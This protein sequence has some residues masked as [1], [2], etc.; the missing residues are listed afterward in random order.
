M[1]I[2]YLLFNF[3]KIPLYFFYPP[4]DALELWV[5]C[6]CYDHMI[7]LSPLWK[8][9]ALLHLFTICHY[10]TLFTW[11][12]YTLSAYRFLLFVNICSLNIIIWLFCPLSVSLSIENLLLLTMS[13]PYFLIFFH[14][15]LPWSDLFFCYAIIMLY[16]VLTWY[17]IL[18][19]WF[20]YLIYIAMSI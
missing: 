12:V 10:V 2:P 6:L 13:C 18:P 4:S 8:F 16:F 19:I 5:V 9:A 1:A 17:Y 11:F 14:Y 7:F 15:Y 20:L 3:S